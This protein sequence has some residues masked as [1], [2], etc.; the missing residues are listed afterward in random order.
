MK[1]RRLNYTFASAIHNTI[2][3]LVTFGAVSSAIATVNP[4]VLATKVAD[5][6]SVAAGAQV[7]FVVTIASNG[8]STASGATLSDPMPD[9]VTWSISGPANGFSLSGGPGS[10]V[11]SFGPTDLASGASASVHLIATSVPSTSTV[12]LTNTATVA[13]HNEAVGDLGDNTATAT[14]T[15]LGPNVRVTKTADAASVAA[16][17]QIG[18]VVT[19][20]SNGG[21]TASGATLNDPMPPGVTWSISGP[22]NGFSLSGSPGS[23]VTSFGPTDLAGGASASVHLVATSVPST[24][25]TVVLTNTATVSA[26]NEAVGDLGDNTATATVTVLSPNVLVTKTAD[27]SSVNAGAQIGFVVTIANNGDGTANGATL[28]DPMP[29]GVTWSISGPANGFSLSGSPGSQ[30]ASFGPTNLAAGASASV[31]LVATSVPNTIHTVVLSNT[32]TVSATNEAARDNGDNTAT[33]TVTV[34]SPNVLVTKTAD[35]ASV[36][37]GAQVGFVVTIASNGDGTANNATLSDPLP[38]GVTWSIS[39]PANGFSLSGSPGSQVTLFGPTDLASGASASVHLVATSVPSTTPTVLLTNT[40]TVSA[41][42]EAARDNGDNTATAS[43]TVQSPVLVG[44]NDLGSKTGADQF[45]RFPDPSTGVAQVVGRLGSSFNQVDGMAILSGLAQAPDRVFGADDN[46]LVEINPNS[47]AATPIG[48]IGFSGVDGL[49]FHPQTRALFGVTYGSNKIIRIDISTGKGTV[50]A[51]HVMEGHRLNDM[52]FSPDGR[53]FIVTNDL[54]P[55]LYQVNPATGAKLNKWVLSGTTQIEAILWSLDGRTLYSSALRGGV[56]DLATVDFAA[57]KVVFVGAQ[58]SGSRDIEAL[59]W[60]GATCQQCPVKVANAPAPTAV[61]ALRLFPNVPNP[62]NPTTR[63]AFDLPQ[64]EDVELSVHDAAG[65]R[66]AMLVHEP[67]SAGHHEV[68]WMGVSE[69]GVRVPS[70]VYFYTLRAGKQVEKRRMLL[71]K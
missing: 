26:T 11:T 51:S 8:G 56:S 67:M 38:A 44:I 13:A 7:G 54:P 63:I 10:Q 6:A 3:I 34:L 71:L 47:G 52:T 23:Q 28:N 5:A 1:H 60:I 40:A 50:V 55:K 41:T 53:M 14:V 32:A 25:H 49:C 36:S 37:A 2:L 21:S 12:V 15:V 68:D 66:V 18:F 48:P 27:V 46:R 39:G 61:T 65:H 42:N 62:F 17:A 69:R 29:A 20:A 30:V 19:I 57:Q 24:I 45:I 33:A 58:H 31:H 16:G 59:A 35:A 9:S 64:G 43:V 22:A 70:G 4:N